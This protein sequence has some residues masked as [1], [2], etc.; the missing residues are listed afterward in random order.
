MALNKKLRA[1][2][3]EDLSKQSYAT[4]FLIS[5][6]YA[7]QN[8]E[9]F[10]DAADKLDNA[11][12]GS[13]SEKITMAEAGIISRV[14]DLSENL[15]E[16]EKHCPALFVGGYLG[17]FTDKAKEATINYKEIEQKIFEEVAL[18]TGDLIFLDEQQNSTLRGK[19][20][21]IEKK[22]FK[23]LISK[24]G[25]VSK[26]LT[27]KT[28]GVDG[29]V[30]VNFLQGHLGFT[31]YG[32]EDSFLLKEYLY[33][34][35]LKIDVTKMVPKEKQEELDIKNPQWREGLQQ[36]YQNIQDRIRLVHGETNYQGMHAKISLSKKIGIG[37][38]KIFSFGKAKKERQDFSEIRNKMFDGQYSASAKGEKGVKNMMCSAFIAR[39]MV[40]SLVELDEFVKNQY[41]VEKA[42]EI[43][44]DKDVKFS[45]LLPG[46]LYDI[47]VEKGICTEVI[48]SKTEARI[49]ANESYVRAVDVNKTPQEKLVKI[50]ENAIAEYRLDKNPSRLDNLRE[51]LVTQVSEVLV[52]EKNSQ[53]IV[54]DEK[55]L[56]FVQ[57]HV[58][59]LVAIVD[60]QDSKSFIK[61][62]AEQAMD[63]V[64]I[65]KSEYSKAVESEVLKIRAILKGSQ[66]KD[67][68]S[69][70]STPVA[71][72]ERTI[73]R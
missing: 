2:S 38:A 64:G 41:G 15:T 71:T 7:T 69:R 22:I 45:K 18:K 70:T 30:E 31:G 59:K 36:E 55:D 72:I 51:S 12:K 28:T 49:F 37:M 23:Q 46:R 25:H 16:V 24:H 44:F 11:Y 6:T 3:E 5:F 61:K 21:G 62:W 48:R 50:A 10:L 34:H 4:N 27:E 43:P 9:R 54:I 58:D 66:I 8:V 52:K 19:S 13:S 33:S 57:T 63:Y 35:I 53:A 73:S 47:L 17:V 42:I 26:L 29:G 20:Y 39:E 56:K 1:I 65:K 60:K 14:V 40:A 67:G 32:A 68:G